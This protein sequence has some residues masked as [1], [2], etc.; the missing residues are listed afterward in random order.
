MDRPKKVKIALI[1]Y[2]FY[3]NIIVAARRFRN[4]RQYL[5]EYP[6]LH[7]DIFTGSFNRESSIQ[8]RFPV[9]LTNVKY[10][11]LY[12]N[13]LE[14]K[15]FA[16]KSA[17][18]H[19]LNRTIFL[20]AAERRFGRKILRQEKLESYDIFYLSLGPFSSLLK[21]A[22]RLKKRIIPRRKY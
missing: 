13:S 6:D 3:P 10:I 16:G 14:K 9:D 21:T 7:L 1:T 17:F 4:V 12:K 18:S 5:A 2:W 19:L 20:G 15:I 11:K 8:D 22:Y